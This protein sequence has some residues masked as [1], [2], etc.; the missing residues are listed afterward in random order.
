M[1]RKVGTGIATTTITKDGPEEPSHDWYSYHQIEFS[2]GTADLLIF[3]D[4]AYQLRTWVTVG[5]VFAGITLLLTVFLRGV[6]SVAKYIGELGDD[7]RA[8]EGGDLTRGVTVRGDDELTELADGLDSMRRA[9]LAQRESEALSLQANQSLIAGLSHDLRTPLTKIMLFVE[10]LRNGRYEDE[11]K[12]RDYLGRLEANAE[13]I[14]RLSD[15]ILQYSLAQSGG[16]K[17][18]AEPRVLSDALCDPLSEMMDFLRERGF[19]LDCPEDLPCDRA[20]VSEGLL[21][22]VLDNL[23]SNID[24]YA[25]RMK[26]VV[27]RMEHDSG[28]AGIAFENA[29]DKKVISLDGAGVGLA[30][31]RYLMGKME[32]S[33]EV[34]YD[35]DA[36]RATLWFKL[37]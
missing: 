6:A 8:M 23:V 20:M 29:V 22:R 15:D 2:D 25:D 13:Q 37:A 27:V 28:R 3:C 4:E 26:P 36:F 16:G 34:R 1:P 31:V 9:F 7:V 12:L 21:Q 30:N 24:K 10:I 32:G 33:C 5:S 14:R 19:D 35:D 18:D 17:G 11:D